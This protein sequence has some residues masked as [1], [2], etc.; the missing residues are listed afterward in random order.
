MLCGI[1][2]IPGFTSVTVFTSFQS[3][4][5]ANS[6]REVSISIECV[7]RDCPVAY[8]FS[9]DYIHNLDPLAKFHTSLFN[10]ANSLL[11]R[12]LPFFL[13][14]N[15]YSKERSQAESWRRECSVIGN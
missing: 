1:R 7:I 6:P 5:R 11:Q 12:V 2:K 10:D 4:D 3:D 8:L 9:R 14:W 15:D 13:S